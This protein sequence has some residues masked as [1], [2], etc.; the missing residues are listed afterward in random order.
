MLFCFII[1]KRLIWTDFPRVYSTFWSSSKS[2]FIKFAHQ[3]N[4]YQQW[5]FRPPIGDI[6]KN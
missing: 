2:F 5:P 6:R 1:I 3:I 4:Y